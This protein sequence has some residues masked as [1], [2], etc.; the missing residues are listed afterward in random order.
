MYFEETGYLTREGLEI[1][2]NKIRTTYRIALENGH[3]SM[4]LGAFGCGVFHLIPE[5]VSK[6]R[7]MEMVAKQNA[8]TA[9]FSKTYEGKTVEILCEDYDEKRDL[10]LG[11][12]EYGRMGYFKSDKNEIGNFVMIKVGKTNGIS[13]YGDKVEQ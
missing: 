6:Q 10:Y 3:D 12:D 4:I 2:K 7:I 1:Q 5:E 9:E 8:R 11:R 13:L